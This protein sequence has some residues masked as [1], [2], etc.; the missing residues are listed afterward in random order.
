MTAYDLRSLSEDSILIGVVLAMMC[1][2]AIFRK[3][4]I[5]LKWFWLCLSI[6][7][8]IVYASTIGRWL[9][10]PLTAGLRWNWSGY[11]MGL[12]A[13]VIILRFMPVTLRAQMGLQLRQAKGS[14][15]VWIG[16]GVYALIFI[17]IALYAPPSKTQHYWESLAF[18][19]TMPSL[20]EELFYRGLFPVILDRC[21]GVS[22][23][24]LG[25]KMGWGAIISSVIF[26]L[27]H[28]LSLKGG[29]SIDWLAVAIPGFI[30]LM[31]C[32]VVSRTKSLLGPIL[33]HSLGNSI[34]YIL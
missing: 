5:D 1:G 33:M 29:F 22:R 7:A 20:N 28:G 26:G 23:N 21:F 19:L 32:W 24:I 30:G 9:A 15:K 34:D 25:A 16:I 10:R 12:T 17:A 13:M 11:I 2:V 8:L 27:A 31:G 14:Q 6:F 3:G 4:Q 18:Q